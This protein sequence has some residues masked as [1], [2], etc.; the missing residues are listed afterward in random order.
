MATFMIT[1]GAGFIGSHLVETVL[2]EGHRAV[3]FDNLS[4]GRRE[5]LAPMRAAITV[6]EG[7][8]RD[9]AALAGAMAGVDYVLHHAAEISAVKS[10]EDPHLAHEV[11]VTG[12]LNVLAAARAAGAR[13]VVL[14]TSSAV[15]GDTGA[16]PQRETD[17]PNP[18]S[19]YGVTKLC[20]EHYCAVFA[21]L[22]GVETVCLRYFNVY[23]PRQNPQSQYAAVIPKFVARL[24]AGQSLTIFGDGEQTRDFV[25]VKDVARANYLACMTEGVS[26]QVINIAGGRSVSVNTLA[27]IL[28]TITGAH[29]EVIHAAPQAGEIKY[30]TSVTEKARAL[31]GFTPSVTLEAGLA[32]VVEYLRAAVA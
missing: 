31:L 27:D 6:I 24:L 16:R 1:G 26:G 21:T 23:G 2:A 17:L 10:V 5:N 3:V 28:M 12:T 4:T 29:G 8:I 25:F 14:A 18:I 13:R 7:D 22:Y 19:P 9:R 32:Q 20:G 11:N 15:Y 30:S